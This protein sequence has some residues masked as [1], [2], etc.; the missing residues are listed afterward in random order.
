MKILITGCLGQLGT[1][2]RTCFERGY[3]KLGVPD[4][5]KKTNEIYAVDINELDISDFSA[6]IELFN[7]QHFDAVI[8]CAAYTDVNGCEYNRDTAFKANALGPRN[9]AIA[10]DKTGAKLIHISTDY[11]FS[12]VGNSPHIEWDKCDPQNV[13][14][15]SKLLGEQYVREF[16]RKYFIVRTSWLYSRTGKNFV[17]TMLKINR[18]KGMCRVVSDQYGNPTNV[19]DLAHHIL[20]LLETEQYGIYHGTGND[21]CSWFEFAEKIVELAGIRSDVQPCSS[22]EYPSPAQRPAYS[23]L[24]NMMFR[25][26]VGDEFRGWEEALADFFSDGGFE[27]EI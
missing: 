7:T 3:T 1:E 17:K 2:L 11:V 26:T 14:G 9:L 12:G 23:A 16:C 24:D 18:E 10:A 21:V 8:N 4:I 27:K 13:Y 22:E 20:K 5:L 6:V 25:N 15:K 19:A